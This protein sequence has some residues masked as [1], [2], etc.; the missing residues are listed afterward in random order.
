MNIFNKTVA[1]GTLLIACATVYAYDFEAGGIYYNVVSVSK[2]TVEVTYKTAEFDPNNPVLSYAGTVNIPATVEY[3]GVTFA[4]TN[5][6]DNAFRECTGLAHITLP[7][8]LQ[9]IGDNAFGGC[10][11][12][13]DVAFP[14]TLTAIGDWAFAGCHSMVNVVIPP[15]VTHIGT[16]AITGEGVLTLTIQDSPNSI[17]VAP[18]F[19]PNI[20]FRF[21]NV[22]QAYVG[23]NCGGWQAPADLTNSWHGPALQRVEFGPYVTEIPYCMLYGDAW[24]LTELILSPNT[25]KIAWGALGGCYALKRI[26]L[27]DA[28][29]EI[30]EAALGGGWDNKDMA[31]TDLVIGPNIKAIGH[32]AF[33]GCRNL[34]TVTVRRPDAIFLPEDAFDAQTY[35]TATLYIPEGSRQTTNSF[36]NQLTKEEVRPEKTSKDEWADIWSEY[37]MAM[38]YGSGYYSDTVSF[39]EE[40]KVTRMGYGETDY[41]RNF[42]RISEGESTEATRW[43]VTIIVSDGGSVRALG[44]DLRSTTCTEN[45]DEGTRLSVLFE[46]DLGWGLTELTLNGADVLA[47]VAGTAYTMPAIDRKDTLRVTFSQPKATLTLRTS[48]Q[49]S[50]EQTVVYGARCTLRITPAEGYIVHSV[51]F[52]GEDITA[53]LSPDGT[54]TTPAVNGDALLAVAFEADPSGIRTERLPALRVLPGNGSVSVQGLRPGT[55]VTAYTTDGVQVALRT[56]ATTTEHITLPTGQVYV[57]TAEGRSVK[58]RL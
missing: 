28:V 43:P 2:R 32:S 41:W 47:D 54:I 5:I 56:A 36:E 30:E 48:E 26:V 1:L 11:G 21:P 23:R 58:V 55:V 16:E 14:S 34:Q 10:T 46:P 15:S 38:G 4:V 53:S 51:T 39:Y 50:V 27:P 37:W 20:G 45:V 18:T 17:T 7:E 22:K 31:V 12:L 49:G 57:I 6:G 8:G 35:L 3:Q 29:E 44:R 24:N 19:H 40:V 25:K 33:A 52:N 9:A 13:A 42:L